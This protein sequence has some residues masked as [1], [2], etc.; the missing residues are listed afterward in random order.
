MDGREPRGDEHGAIFHQGIH[1]QLDMPLRAGIDELV[2]S[3][4]IMTGGSE[5]AARW[6]VVGVA[7]REFAPSPVMTV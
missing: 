5:I 2:A 3:S 4:R 7:L 6:R 1:A